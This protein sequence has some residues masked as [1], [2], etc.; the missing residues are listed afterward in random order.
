[1]RQ[2]KWLDIEDGF[3]L[4]GLDQSAIRTSCEAVR[5]IAEHSSILS[6]PDVEWADTANHTGMRSKDAKLESD[7]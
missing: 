4:L 3:R 6:Q 5:H 7:S 2:E 1:M